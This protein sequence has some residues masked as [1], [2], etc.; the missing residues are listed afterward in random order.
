VRDYQA[1]AAWWAA[2]C[3]CICALVFPFFLT[4]VPPVLDYPNHLA[5]EFVLA[6]GAADPVLSK[7]YAANW[8][9]IPNLAIDL[10]T[11][12]LLHLLPLHV[13]GR[14]VLA[15]SLLLPVAGIIVYSRAR[16]GA[17]SYWSLGGCLVAYNSLF[18]LGFMNCL[19]SVGLALLVAAGWIRYR[20][21]R[22]GATLFAT[23][24]GG[25]AVFLCHIYGLLVLA[26]LLASI[27]SEACLKSNGFSRAAFRK[28]VSRGAAVGAVFVVPAILYSLS[29][30]ESDTSEV[31]YQP[32]L[33]KL[34]IT[35]D[36]FLNYI[37]ILN[38][39]FGL[40]VFSFAVYSLTTGHGRMPLST[41]ISIVIFLISYVLCPFAAKGGA[42]ADARFPVVATFML[43]AG[44][45]P[46][47]LPKRTAFL[48]GILGIVMLGAQVASIAVIWSAHNEDI[49]E[50]RNTISVVEP[51][52]KVL[53]ASVG[54]KDNPDYWQH[55]RTGRRMAISR[56]DLHLP[57]LLVMERRA[58]WPLLFSSPSQQPITVLPPYSSISRTSG[59]LPDYHLLLASNRL[60]QKQVTPYLPY[61]PDWPAKFD[62]V[63]LLNAGGAPDLD[64]FMPNRLEL[65]RRSDMAALF[66][67]RGA[68]ATTASR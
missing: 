64:T 68:E 43:F 58:F 49:A 34:V 38:I 66:R 27:E 41:K 25:I 20:N 10:I 32:V 67:I 40:I 37:P 30:F 39:L 54:I 19:I 61:L 29:P 17:W 46:A 14:M 11:P 24:L 57:A 63:L 31:I 12:P 60:S 44:F 53:V 1:P 13:A 3:L 5:R 4:E 9:I 42:W 15:L 59:V 23:C 18:L 6:F 16:F 65:L 35:F 48:A 51:G 7:I 22:P 28:I 62:Y 8:H 56:T 2:L 50:L 47:Q 33:Y 52:S 45:V 55:N 36:G 26:V 21:V